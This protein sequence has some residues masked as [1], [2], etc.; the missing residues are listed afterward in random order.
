MPTCT[1]RKETRQ[2][3]MDVLRRVYGFNLSSN[4]LMLTHLKL[5]VYSRT[6]SKGNPHPNCVTA[7][8]LQTDEAT[9]S[10]MVIVK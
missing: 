1:K 3:G 5:F 7:M 9:Q 2:T 6:L 8:L 4:K 10:E